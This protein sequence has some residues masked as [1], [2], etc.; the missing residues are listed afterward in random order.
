MY[1]AANMRQP[2]LTTDLIHPISSCPPLR[3]ERLSIIQP[4]N[5]GRRH[6]NGS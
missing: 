3:L 4:Q 6:R 1:Q 2:I 5:V